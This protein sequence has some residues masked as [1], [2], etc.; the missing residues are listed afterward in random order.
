MN[1]TELYWILRFSQCSTLELP[2]KLEFQINNEKHLKYNSYTLTLLILKIISE[3]LTT[4]PK[5]LKT[6]LANPK[7][8]IAWGILSLKNDLLI[9][10]HSNLTSFMFIS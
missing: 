1:F 9:I 4:K 2:D 6:M 10:W 7:K 5:F 8:N 3:V